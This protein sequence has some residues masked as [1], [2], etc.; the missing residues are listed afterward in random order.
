[1]I[2]LD[3]T[4]LLACE[5]GDVPGHPAIRTGFQKALLSGESF[6]V[7]TQVLDEFVHV[8]TDARRFPNPLTM[9]QALGV[10]RTWARAREVELVFPSVESFQQQCLWMEKHGLGRKRILDTALAA[11]Y[12]VHGINR[13]ATRNEKD[14]ALFN[15]F[16][17][18]TWAL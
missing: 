4:T 17:F 3:T 12:Q 16:T 11:I 14:F 10:V 15:A 9:E 5:L 18:E 8:V 13:L 1:M 6:A 2:G 7:A